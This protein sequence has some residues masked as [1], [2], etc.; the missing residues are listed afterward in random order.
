MEE[1]GPKALPI[2]FGAIDD[3]AEQ[4]MVPMRD[5]VRLAT[6][7]YLPPTTPARV[8]LVRLPYDKTGLFSFMPSVAGYV[9]EHGYVFIAQDVRGKAR[10]EGEAF[11]FTS[12]VLDGYDTLEWIEQQRWC[13][14]SVVMFGDSYYGF[15]QWAAAAS[16]HPALKAIVPRVTNTE[17]G[18]DWMYN[19]GV[20]CLETMLDWAAYAWVDEP[21]YEFPDGIDWKHRPLADLVPS[22]FDGRRSASL[23]RWIAAGPADPFWTRGI[24]GDVD[25]RTVGI[26][27][28]HSGGWWDVLRRGQMRDFMHMAG[29][30]APG[31]HLYFEHTDHYDDPLLPEGAS[32]VDYLA[33][34][35]VLETLVPAYVDPALAFYDY[36]IRGT[37]P[38]PPA[39]RW[40]LSGAELRESDTWPPAGSRSMDLF[41]ADAARATQ[42]PEGGMLLTSPERQ[43]G[44]VGWTHDPTDPVPSLIEDAWRPLLGLPD[45]IEVETR[46]DVVTFSTETVREPLDLAGPVDAVLLV[47]SS[48]E[49]THVILKLV[50]V[51]PGGRARRIT[52]GACLVSNAAA[53]QTVNVDMGHVGYRLEAG[54]RLRVEVASS[55]FPRYIVHPG[56]EEDPWLATG[57][58]SEQRLD[59][60]SR[61]GSQI[62]ISVMK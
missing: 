35:S 6:D 14:G 21:L 51:F 50:D 58:P 38:K 33:D 47:G 22:M 26:P 20:F 12:E 49:S 59:T 40:R 37:G 13:D 16:G 10:S 27:V 60:G 34:P 52:E 11:A 2:P 19:Q 48:S 42:G 18:T 4:T 1:H 7:V 28:L 8:M 30:G 56:T 43:G 31:Q 44:V 41:F 23:D 57:K 62:R 5:G 53:G 45:E 9:V 24:Y 17:I 3:R 54:H 46:P 29:A 32:P 55:N 39:V 36:Y 61:S 15:T 25:P